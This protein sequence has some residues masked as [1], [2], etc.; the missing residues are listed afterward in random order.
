M[1]AFN[2]DNS[3][4]IGYSAY[5]G[6]CSTHSDWTTHDAVQAY[7]YEIEQAPGANYDKTS[8]NSRCVNTQDCATFTL[9]KNTKAGECKLQK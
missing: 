6:S 2:S 4:C 8:C 5:T 9:G 3:G 1:V 7:S